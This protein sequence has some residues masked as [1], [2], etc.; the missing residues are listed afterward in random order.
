MRASDFTER[1]RILFQCWHGYRLIFEQGTGLGLDQSYT[2]KVR[3][4]NMTHQQIKYAARN[5]SRA[6]REL[7]TD[8]LW[9]FVFATAVSRGGSM[10]HPFNIDLSDG[11]I[12][13]MHATY[14]SFLT[15]DHQTDF[16]HLKKLGTFEIIRESNMMTLLFEGTVSII[17][18]MR[19]HAEVEN[20]PTNHLS[21]G[22]I[23]GRKIGRLLE[24]CF[25]LEE[26]HKLSKAITGLNGRRIDLT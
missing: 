10:P 11:E 26:H 8:A 20:L 15:H 25:R 19:Y 13:T 24:Q 21:N 14:R 2:P 17:A 12:E 6:V 4:P 5:L 9:L 3:W 1:E 7:R 18:M 16:E 22:G 23:V